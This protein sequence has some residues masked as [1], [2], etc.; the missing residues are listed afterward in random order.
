[1]RADK[2]YFFLARRQK[3]NVGDK[4]STRNKNIDAFHSWREIYVRKIVQFLLRVI[5][6]IFQYVIRRIDLFIYFRII[7]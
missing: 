1:M 5:E 6:D 2:Q 3:R 7:Y 4:F